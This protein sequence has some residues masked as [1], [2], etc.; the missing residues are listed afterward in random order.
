MNNINKTIYKD[1]YTNTQRIQ[2]KGYS[3]KRNS[4]QWKMMLSISMLLVL[5]VAANIYNNRWG[6]NI[7]QLDH[8]IQTLEMNLEKEKII[9]QD[10]SSKARLSN[11]S[12]G[13]INMHYNADSVVVVSK[14]K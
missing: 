12:K 14:F 7:T 4:K 11:Q 6:R 3:Q 2:T 8:S 10:L 5:F 1:K 13:N 9:N